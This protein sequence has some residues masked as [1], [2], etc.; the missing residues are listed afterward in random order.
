MDP[1]KGNFTDSATLRQNYCVATPYTNGE[2]IYEDANATSSRRR[3]VS[4]RLFQELSIIRPMDDGV[5]KQPISAT[6]DNRRAMLDATLPE[7]LQ[8]S[9]PVGGSG[10]SQFY[11]LD[12]GKTGVLALGEIPGDFSENLNPMVDGLRKLVE[13][14]AT[15]LILDLVGG[16][17][18]TLLSKAEGPTVD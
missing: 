12:D 11:M 13:R 5:M 18:F 9:S 6:L 14:G 17:L 3:D 10:V 15:R 8:P 7:G 16:V 4:V 1:S 2:D